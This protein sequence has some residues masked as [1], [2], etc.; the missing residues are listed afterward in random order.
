MLRSDNFKLQ[1]RKRHPSKI[2]LPMRAE[3]LRSTRTRQ[4]KRTA[5]Q[6]NAIVRLRSSVP[7]HDGLRSFPLA[8]TSLRRATLGRHAACRT[9]AA[10]EAILQPRVRVARTPWSPALMTPR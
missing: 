1:V 5:I 10:F 9:I 8:P 2:G 3:P 4:D 7:R 6:D